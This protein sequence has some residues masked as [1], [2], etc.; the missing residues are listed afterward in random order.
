[1]VNF[2]TALRNFSTPEWRSQ[3]ISYVDL[4]DI[5]ESIQTEKSK[6]IYVTTKLIDQFTTL[7]KENIDK[8]N[9]FVKKMEAKYIE[10]Q[11]QLTEQ[12]DVWVC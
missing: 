1:M 4:R 5:V 8:I 11:K 3:Y 6:G 2:A 12:L 9:A 10:R 7:I